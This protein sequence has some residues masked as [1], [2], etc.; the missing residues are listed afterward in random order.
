MDL[1]KSQGKHKLDKH[2]FESSLSI[3]MQGPKLSAEALKRRN[4]VNTAAQNSGPS[5][6]ADTPRSQQSAKKLHAASFREREREA[7]AKENVPNKLNSTS[8]QISLDAEATSQSSKDQ[9]LRDQV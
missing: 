3:T 6:V 1:L 7:Q 9:E 4:A 8:R 5:S 2:L